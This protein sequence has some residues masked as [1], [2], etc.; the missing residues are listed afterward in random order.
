[1]QAHIRDLEGQVSKHKSHI[2]SVL[3][4]MTMAIEVAV[5][6]EESGQNEEIAKLEEV[7]VDYIK[8]EQQ[9]TTHVSAL[10]SVKENIIRNMNLFSNSEEA[11]DLVAMFDSKLQD[12][13]NEHDEEDENKIKS[14]PKYREFRQKVWAVNHQ[15]EALP[16]D[17]EIMVMNT[18]GEF[19]CP[20]SRSEMEEP[21]KK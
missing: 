13:Q 19:I 14:H 9:L 20:L 21:L 3:L 16:D 8:M 1:M 4:S 7:I 2:Q 12:S 15:G 6:L 5:A 17:D 18:A 10:V 11:P